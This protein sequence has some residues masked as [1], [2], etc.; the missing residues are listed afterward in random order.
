MKKSLLIIVFAALGVFVSQVFAQ[1]QEPVK[2]A[3]QDAVQKTEMKKEET[4]AVAKEK[5]AESKKQGDANDAMKSTGEKVK[6]VR[7][8]G[9]KKTDDAKKSVEK[10]TGTKDDVK[11]EAE[12]K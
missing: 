12:K 6:P 10:A 5:V 4:R 1:T 8:H 11:K 2:A 9:M 3:G 7:K